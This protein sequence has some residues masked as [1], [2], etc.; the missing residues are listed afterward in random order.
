V[1]NK[2]IFLL[3]NEQ[4]AY[5]AINAI[6]QIRLDGL[7]EIEIRP[8]KQTRKLNQNAALWAVAYPAVM[9]A[10][11]LRGEKE[12]EEIHEYF[13]GEFWGWKQY[14]ILNKLK[15]KPVRTTTKNEDGK[16][17][18]ISKSV[19]YDFYCFIQQRGAENGIFVPDPDPLYGLK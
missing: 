8:R 7:T 6:K 13:C 2:Q 11:G 19:M 17:D 1:N 12:R 9:E 18:V 15:Q 14:R 16:K 4:V 5:N 10:M 3:I